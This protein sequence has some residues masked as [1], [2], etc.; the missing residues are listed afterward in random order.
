MLR[1]MLVPLLLATVV[2]CAPS[3]AWPPS[4]RAWKQVDSFQCDFVAR[5]PGTPV[6]REWTEPKGVK[7]LEY[8]TLSGQYQYMAECLSAGQ[9]SRGE[10]AESLVRARL[11]FEKDAVERQHW[12][13]LEASLVPLGQCPGYRLISVN[14][15]GLEVAIRYVWAGDRAFLLGASGPHGDPATATVRATLFESLRSKRCQ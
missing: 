12:P 9:V 2:G 4:A 13:L 7:V 11:Q 1:S 6:L 10:T 8:A 3:R 5:L 15:A 14:Q